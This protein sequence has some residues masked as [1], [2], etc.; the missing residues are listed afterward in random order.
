MKNGN[1]Q[2]PGNIALT[3]RKYCLI[4]CAFHVFRGSKESLISPAKA[5]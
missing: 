4:F 3:F 5:I 1:K 2:S